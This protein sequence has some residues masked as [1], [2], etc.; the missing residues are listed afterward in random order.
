MYGKNVYQVGD[1][2]DSKLSIIYIFMSFLF[3]IWS[4]NRNHRVHK[5]LKLRRL[6]LGL[7]AAGKIAGMM[8]YKLKRWVM[9]IVLILGNKVCYVLD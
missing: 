2:H 9:R 4:R 1:F 5:S 7:F 3:S 8:E 6:S